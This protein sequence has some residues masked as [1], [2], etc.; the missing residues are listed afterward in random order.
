MPRKLK[1]KVVQ[2]EP[3]VQRVILLE[4]TDG[5]SVTSGAQRL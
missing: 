2:D 1:I 3:E 5:L 4:V